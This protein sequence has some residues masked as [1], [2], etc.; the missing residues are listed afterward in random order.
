M[1]D[2]GFETDEEEF[3]PEGFIGDVVDSER[4]ETDDESM[5]VSN[6][7]TGN[8]RRHEPDPMALFLWSQARKTGPEFV[9]DEWKSVNQG[10]LIKSYTAHPVASV[11]AAQLADS[12]C[13]DLKF[14]E[15][16][17]LEKQVIVFPRFGG[18]DNKNVF[19]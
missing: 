1:P 6:K 11:F 15:K 17:D 7:F 9:E 18:W 2:D 10:S 19:S 5:E 3:H 12:E 16:V 13:P 8:K 4:E 14:K